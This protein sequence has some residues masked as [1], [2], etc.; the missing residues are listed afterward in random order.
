MNEVPVLNFQDGILL[1]LH[2]Y[3]LCVRCYA[4]LYVRVIIDCDGTKEGSD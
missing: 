1:S 3:L 4:L 2:I